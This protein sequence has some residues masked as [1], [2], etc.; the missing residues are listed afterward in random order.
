VVATPVHLIF[1]Y[2]TNGSGTTITATCNG[3]G[4]PYS[5]TLAAREN[6]ARPILAASP[7]CGWTWHQSSADTPD[8][9]YAVSSHVV[10]HVTWAVTGAPGGGDLGDLAGAT[11]A[12]R[13]SVG[14]I[15]AVNTPPR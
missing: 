5:D 13:V 6:T 1:D 15:Q 8:Q 4:T 2:Q 12:F 14:E 3:P 7:D 10:Y 11:T 9:K